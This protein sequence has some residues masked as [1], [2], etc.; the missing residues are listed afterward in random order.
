MSDTQASDCSY[1]HEIRSIMQDNPWQDGTRTGI[2]EGGEFA[3][4]TGRSPDS[5]HLR[6]AIEAMRSF[7]PSTAAIA[8]YV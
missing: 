5:Q 3:P 1:R 4:P 2:K 8:S 6:D 7:D